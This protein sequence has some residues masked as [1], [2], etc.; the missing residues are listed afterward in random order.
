MAEYENRERFIPFRKSEIITLACEEGTFD[1]AEQEKFLSVCKILESIYHFEFHKKSELLKENYYPFNPDKDTRTMRNYSPEDIR[2]SENNL[3]ENFKAILNDANYEEITEEDLAYAIEKESLFQI[4]LL[5]DFDDFDSRLIFWRGIKS[6]KVTFKKWFVKKMEVDIPIFERVAMLIKFKDAAYF[7]AK[8]RKDLHFEPESMIIKLFKNI[9]KADI[10]MLFPNTQVRMKLKDMLLM[11]GTAIGGGIAVFLKTSAG[12][13]AMASVLWFMISSF[14]TGGDIPPLRPAEISGMIAGVSA[15][16][17]LGGFVLK[18]WNNYKNRK[19]RFM[20]TL[21]DNL[22]FKNL[23]NNAGVFHHIIDAAEEE[24]CKEAVL[25]YYFLLRDGNGLTESA[26]DNVI[27][28]WF[29]NTHDVRVDFEIKDALRKLKE[30]ALCKVIGQDEKGE[31]I[32]QAVSLDMALE[33]LDYIWDN[34]FQFN[35]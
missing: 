23:G 21:G 1:H 20:K 34:Y 28:A 30:L 14:I 32:F 9:P 31:D 3:I 25:S 19:I 10:E 11:G 24:E 29:E 15:L 8:K 13:I 5:V 17:A 2:K 35:V 16:A 6:K 4:S 22:Y 26:L 12:L 27:E 33:R 18:Q 7:E